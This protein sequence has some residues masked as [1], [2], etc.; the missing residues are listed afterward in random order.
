[1]SSEETFDLVV[2]GQHPWQTSFVIHKQKLQYEKKKKKKLL[3][4]DTKI[5]RTF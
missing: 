2:L 4:S 3:F 5:Y 1:M